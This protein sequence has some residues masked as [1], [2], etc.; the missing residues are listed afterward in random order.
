MK[1]PH[2]DA[3]RAKFERTQAAA[4]GTLAVAGTGIAVGFEG[5]FYVL[6][7]AL[8]MIVVWNA[9]IFWACFTDIQMAMRE[10]DNSRT[11]YD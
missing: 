8:C 2:E 1:S 7:V 4:T 11:Y 6:L 5:G 9:W 3:A 10:D